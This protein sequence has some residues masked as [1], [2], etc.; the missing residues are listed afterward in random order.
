VRGYPVD[1]DQTNRR[2]CFLLAFSVYS[3]ELFDIQIGSSKVDV[4]QIALAG[5]GALAYGVSSAFAIRVAVSWALLLGLG[6]ALL[7]TFNYDT[8]TLLWQGGPAALTYFGFAGL[9]GRVSG[10]TLVRTYKRVTFGVALIGLLQFAMSL[11]GVKILMQTSGRLDSIV[12]EPSHYA[13]AISP[14][15]YMSLRSIIRKR[16]VFSIAANFTEYVIIASL[17]L[18]FS[19]SG[20]LALLLCVVLPTLHARGIGVFFVIV[21]IGTAAYLN[22]KLLP[23]EVGSRL[24]A[25]KD[26]TAEETSP[27]EV[28]NLSVYSALTNLEVAI[29]SIGHGRILGNGFGGHA[30]AYDEYVK[31]KG[32]FQIARRERFNVIAAHSLVIRVLS[33][34]GV[35]GVWIYFTWILKG[36]HSRNNDRRIWWTLSSIYFFGR[37]FKLGGYFEIGMPLFLLAPLVFHGWQQETIRPLNKQFVRRPAE[38]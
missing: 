33:E 13:I 4:F 7:T 38:S 14:A 30:A 28:N 31:R 32:Y 5:Y 2:L 9:I 12:Y 27:F 22:P 16:N 24:E 1:W 29:D 6:Y 10:T 36:I 35:I 37:M 20:Y 3:K 25:L 17:L 19:L 23:S 8:R 21:I 15:A 18:T 26:A 11:A 34:F